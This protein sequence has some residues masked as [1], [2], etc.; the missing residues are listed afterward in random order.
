MKGYFENSSNFVKLFILLAIVLTCTILGVCVSTVYL[1]AFKSADTVANTQAL[2]FLQNGCLFV[3]SPFIAQYL[4][5]KAPLKE[6]LGFYSPK[7][8]VLLLGIFSI[9]SITP[10]IEMLTTWNSEM[11]LPDSMKAIEQWMINSE[12]AAEAVT[13]QLLGARGWG[14]FFINVIVIGVM[15]G[16]GEELTFR[17][18]LQKF[19]I[20]WTKNTHAG[21]LITAF[22]F[23]AIHL[24]FFG[25]APRFALGALLGYMFAFSGNIWIPIIAHTLNNVMVVIA[26]NNVLSG[27]SKAIE[28]LKEFHSPVCLGILSLAF[29]CFLMTALKKRSRS[30]TEIQQ[31]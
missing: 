24:Q 27:E 11:H 7:L 6:A 31:K 15:A 8:P 4:L 26:S 19:F 5:W 1:L 20:G 9:F 29:V 2:L 13:Q 3:L 25:F 14:N 12:K 17:G 21:V 22:I 30:K 10:F 28:D 23:S 18:V 16:V